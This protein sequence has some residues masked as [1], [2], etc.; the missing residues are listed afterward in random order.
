M[1]LYIHV[2][3]CAQRCSYCDFYTQ[4]NL[5][6][7]AAYLQALLRELES[8][9]AELPEGET[10]EHIYLGGGTPS[11]LSPEELTAIF[12]LIGRLYPRLGADAEVTL[13][14]NP[15]DITPEYASALSQLPINRV[16]MGLQSFHAADLAFLNRRHTAEQAIEAVALLRQN[17]ITELSLDLIYGL[18]NQRI[19]AWEY[20]IERMIALDVPHISAYHLIY[21]EGTPLTKAM[22]RGQVQQVGEELS[23]AMLRVLIERL[24]D[25]GYQHYEISNFARPGHHARL[26]TGYWQGER[27]IGLGPAAHSYDGHS[28]SYNVASLRDYVAGWSRG[29]RIYTTEM[30]SD[31]DRHNEYLMTRLRT[32]WGIDLEDMARVCGMEAV[33]RLER[34]AMP[35][36]ER[37]VLTR[38]S[39]CLRLG[40]EGIFISDS[41]LVDLFI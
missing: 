11:L 20:N 3:F 30:L 17:G 18:P 12:E 36:L 29:E 34:L 6:L 37:G 9:R 38:S 4:T 25:A 27:Y 10:L 13:E 28:R 5:G 32:M 1:N 16:S 15:D 24:E 22:L 26:N 21:E 14:A 2:P 31:I 40:A 23:L 39:R 35:Y 7:R 41:I 33:S 19:D 8:R